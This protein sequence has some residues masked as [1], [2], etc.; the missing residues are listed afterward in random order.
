MKL[1]CI[2]P[3][4]PLPSV[5]GVV[6]NRCRQGVP[7]RLGFKRVMDLGTRVSSGSVFPQELFQCVQ[8]HGRVE[9]ELST[10][11]ESRT[12]GKGFQ[13][14]LLQC[15]RFDSEGKH[16]RDAPYYR[17][18]SPP[19][20]FHK[21]LSPRSS[22]PIS[23][24]GS[25][26][27][28]DDSSVFHGG[29][30]YPSCLS[31]CGNSPARLGSPVFHNRRSMLSRPVL[32]IRSKDSTRSIHTHNTSGA[33][34]NGTHGVPPIDGLPGRILLGRSLVSDLDDPLCPHLCAGKP[35]IIYPL[36]EANSTHPSNR[37]SGLSVGFSADAGVSTQREDIRYSESHRPSVVFPV[38]TAQD[39]GT[40]GRQTKLRGKG[41]VWR[42]DFSPSHHR[43]DCAPQT[44]GEERSPSVTS[45]DSRP[46]VVATVY[47]P[48][49][50]KST[51][52]RRR[53]S[54]GFNARNR[55]VR[56]CSGSSVSRS[57]DLS[58]LGSKSKV[59]AHKC[60]G[61]LCVY[62]SHQRVGPSSAQ[63]TH[64][65]CPQ[66]RSAVGQYNCNFMDKQGNCKG[67]ASYGTTERVVLE[68][69]HVGLQSNLC[70]HTW[71]KKCNCRCCIQ[72]TVQQNSKPLF[73]QQS[74]S[75]L[76]HRANLDSEAKYYMNNSLAETSR[77]GKI[78]QMRSFVRFAV[79]MGVTPLSPSEHFLIQ[80]VCFLARTLPSD[81]ILGYLDGV[82]ILHNWSSLQFDWSRKACPR[83]HLVLSGIRHKGVPPAGVKKA[84]FG[85]KELLSLKR[86]CFQFDVGSIQR[87]AW[88]AIIIS[89]WGCLRSDNVVPKTEIAFDPLRQ[90]C[91]ANMSWIPEGILVVL[92]KTKTRSFHGPGLR[93]LLPVLDNLVDLCPVGAVNSFLAVVPSSKSGPLLL[94]LKGGHWVPLLYRDLRKVI[95]A[96]SSFMGFEPGKYGSQSARS[97]AATAAFRGGVDAIGIKRLG[98]WLSDTFLSYVRQDVLD[99]LEIQSKILSAL[100]NEDVD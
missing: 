83:L 93:V 61:T 56:Q 24:I 55:C 92:T 86:F 25:R 36:E 9:T 66:A 29:D 30:R 5:E 27:T 80:Y 81:S 84:T 71:D 16:N 58:S 18:E 19:R 50:W 97:G 10:G 13:N 45:S 68:V 34:D 4:T 12:S 74:Q 26:A 41:G 96:W 8:Q 51:D 62:C 54:V 57:S 1:G 43:S 37:I 87:A 20:V 53:Q 2:Y 17:F 3:S 78:S 90:I 69:R 48:M 28:D 39:L 85:S 94:F 38:A 22:L 23:N 98:D 15:D 64:S 7:S 89:F 31:S 46:E 91:L 79:I 59:V 11:I 75:S 65:I 42:K 67:Q 47:D 49:E 95:V 21:R 32:V 70:T 14:R 6:G 99:L 40:A 63:E 100:V 44:T 60:K 77:P 88:V 73:N 76:F 33:E 35:R 82:R 72:A 52:T